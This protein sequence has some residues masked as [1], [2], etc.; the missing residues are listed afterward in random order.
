MLGRVQQPQAARSTEQRQRERV[1]AQQ[2]QERT[3][4]P[5]ADLLRQRLPTRQDPAQPRDKPRKMPTPT[6]TVN[7]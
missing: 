4:T 5:V 3:M 6:L 2:P 1:K 7:S